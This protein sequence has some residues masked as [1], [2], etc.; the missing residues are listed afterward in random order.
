MPLK[1]PIVMTPTVFSGFELIFALNRTDT[2]SDWASK[3]DVVDRVVVGKRKREEHRERSQEGESKI[4][5]CD[6][7]EESSGEDVGGG[8]TRGREVSVAH[9]L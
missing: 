7:V 2:A 9:V 6:H 8:R 1:P 5:C 4:S 3:P